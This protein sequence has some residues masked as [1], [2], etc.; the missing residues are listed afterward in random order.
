[1]TKFAFHFFLLLISIS[2][3]AASSDWT[4][5]V[6]KGC[7]SL[8]LCA[9][10]TG[11]T[12]AAAERSARV[13]LS[14]IFDT[15]ISSK[16]AT[17]LKSSGSD[18]E[19]SVSED[20][21]EATESALAGVEITKGHEDK[22]TFYSLAVVNKSKAAGGFKKEIEN[23][24][25]QMKAIAKDGES[26]EKIKLEKL[27]VRREVLNKQYQFLTNQSL[28]SPVS[29]EEVFA[30][31]KSASNDV[32]IHVYLDE[33][34]P[35]TIEAA[36]IRVISDMGFQAT[37]GQT[38]NKAATHIITGEY[39]SDKQYLKVEGF[40]K[41][42]FVLKVKAMKALSK[43]ES[44]HL[45]FESIETARDFSQANDKALPKFQEYIKSNIEKL[46]LK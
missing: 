10:G 3:M 36:L 11:D 18:V 23:I 28:A 33:D 40:E 2:A 4:T 15:K 7:K 1:M 38:R 32:I 30:A 25:E 31:K 46:N 44:G 9:I 16:L 24:D 34:E 39:V 5:D 29:Y 26:I 19:E 17:S 27:F 21:S 20:I 35:K 6:K 37:S 13:S 12:R 22:T 14:K 42:K 8:E 43:V 45:D 41:Y